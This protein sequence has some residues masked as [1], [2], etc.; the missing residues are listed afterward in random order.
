VV[1]LIANMHTWLIIRNFETLTQTSSM[2]FNQVYTFTVTIT[3]PF[4]S[5]SLDRH[6]NIIRGE[7][8]VLNW[9][10]TNE[11]QGS[12]YNVSIF[13][14]TPMYANKRIENMSLRHLQSAFACT[15]YKHNI[16]DREVAAITRRFVSMISIWGQRC[17][18][19]NTFRHRDT[20]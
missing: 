7:N 2:C 3:V 8:I 16:C 17:Q 6:N 1:S 9:K 20:K 5:S 12:F 18:K 14:F 13:T 4:T 19:R 10:E 15:D 11:K